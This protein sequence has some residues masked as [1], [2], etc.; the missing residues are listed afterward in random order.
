MSLLYRF[1]HWLKSAFGEQ[2]ENHPYRETAQVLA[3]T[4]TQ[5]QA[6]AEWLASEW[7]MAQAQ[8]KAAEL[9]QDVAGVAQWQLTL[10][11]LQSQ[12]QALAGQQGEL[13][14]LQEQLL[15]AARQ[16]ES[17]ATLQSQQAALDRQWQALQAQITKFWENES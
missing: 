12:R 11:T 5:L 15:E 8:R 13:A 1:T 9:T 14:R 16:A 2:D 10:A 4:S 7:A 17:Q 6:R 3:Q